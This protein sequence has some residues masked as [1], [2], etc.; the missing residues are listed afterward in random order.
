MKPNSILLMAALIFAIGV[1][2]S[3]AQPQT[4]QQ[5]KPKTDRD[6]EII[7]AVRAVLDAQKDAWN[8]GDIEGFM[9]G[10]ER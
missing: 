1:P 10:Y 4:S 5:A 8:R 7:S 6:A 2:T 3:W 9:D